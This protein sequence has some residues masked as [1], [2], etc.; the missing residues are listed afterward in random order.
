MEENDGMREGVVMREDPA[1]ELDDQMVVKDMMVT[2]YADLASSER[3]EVEALKRAGEKWDGCQAARR[4]WARVTRVGWGW[5][6]CFSSGLRGTERSKSWDLSR[7][8]WGVCNLVV[9]FYFFCSGFCA[10][11][12]TSHTGSYANE[13]ATRGKETIRYTF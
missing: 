5:K 11:R 8:L 13:G 3:L 10:F 4:L 6:C 7:D 9:F 2:E 1:M 12:D